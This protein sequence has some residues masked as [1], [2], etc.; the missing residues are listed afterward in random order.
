MVIAEKKSKKFCPRKNPS[1]TSFKALQ[2][3][4]SDR[5]SIPRSIEKNQARTLRSKAQRHGLERND[6]LE[7]PLRSLSVKRTG[8]RTDLPREPL[9]FIDKKDLTP[10]T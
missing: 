2:R 9:I 5:S 6:L 10:P 1:S 8:P 7:K 3:T 4:Q